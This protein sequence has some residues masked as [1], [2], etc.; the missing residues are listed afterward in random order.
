MKQLILIFQTTIMFSMLSAIVMIGL[1]LQAQ[2]NGT[3][4]GYGTYSHNYLTAGVNDAERECENNAEGDCSFVSGTQSVTSASAD[5]SFAAG[6]RSIVEAPG[7]YAFG[8][9][10]LIQTGGQESYLFGS[11]LSNNVAQSFMLGWGS[12]LLYAD[13]NDPAGNGFLGIN[14]TA[15]VNTSNDIDLS[16]SNWIECGASSMLLSPSDIRLK[17]DIQPFEDG[18]EVLMQFDPVSFR[19]NGK[20]NFPTNEKKIG[21]IAQ[22]VQKYAPYMVKGVQGKDSY[23]SYDASPLLYILINSVQEQQEMI[24]NQRDMLK[25][26]KD[27]IVILEERMDNLFGEMTGSIDS[28][29]NIN[30]NVEYVSIT[31]T[32]VDEPMLFQNRP[33]PFSGSTTIRYYVPEDIVNAE[34]IIVATES[35]QLL[36]RVAINDTGMGTL[37]LNVKN[38]AT[39]QYTYTLIL[40]G[41]QA[42]SRQMIMSR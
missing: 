37:H 17:Q 12:P 5:F 18:L 27:R 28:T 4:A 26:Y 30:S 11:N 22:E 20:L 38:N 33:N 16:V 13:L 34:I 41:H 24:E 10:I 31:N 6:I 35:G 29:G 36:K 25:N 15:V 9:D 8:N 3:C 40:D 7:A 1:N 23:L 19:Y 21:I 2:C 14:R 42:L 39:G 32:S